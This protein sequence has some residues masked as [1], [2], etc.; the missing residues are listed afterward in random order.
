MFHN[1]PILSLL[2]WLPIFGAI[3]VLM[4]R[5]PENANKARWLSF[6]I[7]LVSLGLCALLLLQ[8]NADDP[9]MQFR[10]RLPWITVLHVYYDVGVDGISLPLII[11]TCFT[12]FLIV[13]ASWS[14]VKNRVA[15]YLA[16]FLLMQGMVVGVF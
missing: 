2:I 5:G 11:L 6:F 15:E 4:L 1:F 3:P 12:T 14:M 16:V 10:D 13:L 7:A 8:F 9:G